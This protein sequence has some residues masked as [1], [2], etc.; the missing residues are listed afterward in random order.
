MSCNLNNLIFESTPVSAC[1]YQSFNFL[2][3]NSK[4]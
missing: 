4:L 1:E 3:V 2:I